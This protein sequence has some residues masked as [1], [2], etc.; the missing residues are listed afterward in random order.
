MIIGMSNITNLADSPQ[1]KN[2]TLKLIEESFQYSS[3][4]R[5]DVDFYPLF[6]EDNFENCHILIENDEV[7]GHIGCLQKDIELLSTHK[8]NMFGGIAIKDEYRGKG[9]FSSLFSHVLN[10]YSDACLSFLWS[11]KL[12]LYERF[13]FYPCVNLI[14]YLKNEKNISSDWIETELKNLTPD[15]LKQVKDLYSA[16]DEVRLLRT[17]VDWSQ[18]AQI[19][20]TRLFIKKDSDKIHNYFFIDKGQDLT[21]IVHEYGVIN[22]LDLSEMISIGNVWSPYIS[23]KKF[24]CRELFGSVVKIENTDAF[25]NFLSEFAG[26]EFLKQT[27]QEVTIKLDEEEFTLKIKDFLPGLF[28]P[29]KFAEFDTPDLFISGLDSI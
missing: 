18:L 2:K 7:I 25:K 4:F 19:T 24:L 11:E 9:K 20:S 17:D 23:E 5:F 14:H 16:S 21:E 8:V 26:A 15:E 6:N 28:G 12:S 10:L 27:D 13:H 22:D 29:G 1:Y 3:S